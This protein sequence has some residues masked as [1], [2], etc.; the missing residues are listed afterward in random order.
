M[1]NIKD[2]ICDGGPCGPAGGD[3]N[4]I[5]T[6]IGS[7][8]ISGISAVIETLTEKNDEK[9]SLKKTNKKNNQ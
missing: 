4:P 7:A 8:I 3:C 2:V 5:P 6:I 9:E 1:K